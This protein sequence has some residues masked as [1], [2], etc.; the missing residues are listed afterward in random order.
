MLVVLSF[1]VLMFVVLNTVL[2]TTGHNLG[3]NFDSIK[4]AG[5]HWLALRFDRWH[6]IV[7]YIYIYIYTTAEFQ[8][9]RAG[10]GQLQPN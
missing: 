2:G 9:G 4:D 3:G 7:Q 10:E 6:H 5:I 8:K 1:V